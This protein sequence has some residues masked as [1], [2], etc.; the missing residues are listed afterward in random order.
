MEG[1]Q[2]ERPQQK[3]SREAQANSKQKA[4]LA[5]KEAKVMQNGTLPPNKN[6]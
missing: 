4:S 1:E 6:A 5:L 2:G 3:L